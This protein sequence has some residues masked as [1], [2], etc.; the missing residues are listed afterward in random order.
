MENL[1]EQALWAAIRADGTIAAITTKIYVDIAPSTAPDS[2][3]ILSL[4]AGTYDNDISVDGS[5]LRYL[6]KAVSNSQQT[7]DN[8]ASALYTLL[9]EN[10]LSLSGGTWTN[11][12]IQVTQTIRLTESGDERQQ[13]FHRGYIVRIRSSK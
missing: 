8:I 2:Y 3:I 7:A 4:N 12:R 9:H 13:F 5:D 11:Y 1:V 6:V 10:P